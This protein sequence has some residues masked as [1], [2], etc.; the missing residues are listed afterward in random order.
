MRDGK[1]LNKNRKIIQMA[2][3]RFWETKTLEEMSQEEWESLCDRC[4]KCCLN[5]IHYEGN[6]HVI[7]TNVACKLFDPLTC[8][9]SNYPNRKKFVEDCIKLTPEEVKKNSDLPSTCAYR[10]VL[11][12]KPLP[13]WHH[14]VSGSEQEVLKQ[15][16]SL[17]GK[18]ASER[19]IKD[20]DLDRHIIR[21]VKPDIDH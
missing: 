5:K 11:K 9:C 17:K 14:L 3:E 16:D 20:E 4:G 1:S 10:L 15:E 6:R 21:W 19:D 2:K 8:K 12:K 18:I 13:A 7:Y